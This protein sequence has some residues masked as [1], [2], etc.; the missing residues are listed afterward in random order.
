MAE[1]SRQ[2]WMDQLL[3]HRALDPQ[4]KM[5]VKQAHKGL[6]EPPHHH[7]FS[8]LP[9][10]IGQQI[11][12]PVKTLWEAM[13]YLK[14]YTCSIRSSNLLHISSQRLRTDARDT[15]LIPVAFADC[16]RKSRAKFLFITVTKR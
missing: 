14:L 13:T 2:T 6:P 15:A 12:C 7:Y 10:I 3:V 4:D 8:P 16:G 11:S 5:H 9:D 1:E